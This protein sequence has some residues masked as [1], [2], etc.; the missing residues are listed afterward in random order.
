MDPFHTQ[1]RR[2]LTL[3]HA[4]SLVI[5][6]TIGTGIFLKSAVM[7]QAVG[8]PLLVLAAWVVAGIVAMFGALSFAELG[9]LLPNSG[10]EYVYLRAAFGE[11]PGFLYV[12]NS[13]L[14]GG[15]SISAYGAAVAVFLSDIY[16]FG[17]VWFQH[18][19]HVFGASYTLQLGLRQ[20]IAVSVIAVFGLVNCAGVIFG[21]RVQTLLTAAKVV[22]ILGVAAGVFLFGS[23]HDWSNLAASP[24]TVSGGLSG[25]GAAMFAAL[26]A[27]SGWQFLP[28]AAS[29][30][31]QPDRNL[32]RAIIG[33]TLIVLAIYMLI[34]VAYL[35][36][37]PIGQVATANSTAYPEAPSVA[38]RAV[39]TFLGTKAA[40]IAALI[41]LVSS[42]GAL[43]GTILARARVPYAAAR[44]GLFFA[45]FGKLSPH[46][47][48]PLT[49]IVLVS[50][51]AALLAVTGTF[52]QLTNMA[53]LS[54]AIFWAPVVFSV[55]VLRRKMPEAPR[56]YRV[57]GY[58]FVPLLFVLVMCWIVVNAFL[59]NTVESVATL[60]LILLGIPLYPLFRG[61]GITQVDS[62]S[63]RVSG[64][65]LRNQNP[66]PASE[67]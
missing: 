15:A 57:L 67:K 35:Y 64:A 56:P 52:D 47:R 2:D 31:Q 29:E 45:R 50:G 26:W 27:Y 11:M 25:F 23:T 62:S 10:G 39:Q 8:T 53:V 3:L 41:F 16:P 38:A 1:P 60:A 12:F 24:G 43:N 44:D 34:N 46:S 51:W 9:A 54:Y 19:M 37:L 40:P 58:P 49:S 18:T 36:A 61:K 32:P 21:G 6:I 66:T 63:Q 33:G 28:M 48:V 13:F 5:G 42:V 4:T 17:G 30:V 22:S 65:P 7:A 20:L 59:T 55:I 14:V